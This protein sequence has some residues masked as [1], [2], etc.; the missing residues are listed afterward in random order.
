MTEFAVDT[1]VLVE[2]LQVVG[3][4]EV[5]G[6]VK[7][8]IADIDQLIGHLDAC[9]GV[10]ALDALA[11][12][13]HHLSGGCRTMGLVSIGAVSA[14]IEADA[15][16]RRNDKFAQYSEQLSQQREALGEW[17]AAAPA[18]PLLSEFWPPA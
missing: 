9:N 8:V 12:E 4:D 13:A 18:D 10:D 11:R 16:E 7:S 15:R 3:A 14:R 17:W 5:G 1:T 2:V 6:F